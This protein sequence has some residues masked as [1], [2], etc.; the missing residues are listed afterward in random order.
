MLLATVQ[1]GAWKRRA[2]L[3]ATRA[4]QFAHS[5]SDSTAAISIAASALRMATTGYG[6]IGRSATRTC[7]SP[8]VLPTHARLTRSRW[9]RWA[10][11]LSACQL[12]GVGS[13]AMIGIIIRYASSHRASRPSQRPSH[14]KR[15]QPGE[16]L[17]HCMASSAQQPALKSPNRS[18]RSA[19]LRNSSGP[20]P[21]QGTRWHKPQSRVYQVE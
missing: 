10:T 3:N 11:L 6:L 15:T 1:F 4:R 8:H 21:L 14:A 7:S 20:D 18:R 19:A 9:G 13:S 12:W 2:T 17:H 5:C 16:A